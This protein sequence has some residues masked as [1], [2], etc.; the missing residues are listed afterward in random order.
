M[1]AEDQQDATVRTEG[2]TDGSSDE[3]ENAHAQNA[4]AQNETRMPQVAEDPWETIEAQKDAT[5]RTGG[6]TGGWEFR[7]DGSFDAAENWR[8]IQNVHA[9][10][11]TAQ[12]I[13]DPSMEPFS[14]VQD[15]M[16]V[17]MEKDGRDIERAAQVLEERF[18]QWDRDEQN[19]RRQVF[20]EQVQET[21]SNT[22]VA[23]GWNNNEADANEVCIENEDMVVDWWLQVVYI[24]NLAGVAN[25]R[26]LEE[27]FSQIGLV[28]EAGVEREGCGWVKFQEVEDAVKAIERFDGAEWG[29]LAMICGSSESVWEAQ[30]D[31]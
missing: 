30:A 21:F 8:R 11:E 3:T 14:V 5:V 18:L 2:Q 19:S 10:N 1:E 15:M 6:Q 16:D 22:A 28:L 7:S 4:H 9:Q 24:A 13:E 12:G 31:Y 27:A 20:M 26:M 23:E 29:G 25:E 17:A